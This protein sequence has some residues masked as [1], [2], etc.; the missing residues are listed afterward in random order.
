M[1]CFLMWTWR[2]FSDIWRIQVKRLGV[3]HLTNLVI[4]WELNFLVD[5]WVCILIFVVIFPWK[6]YLKLFIE[7]L[8][9]CFSFLNFIRRC[10]KLVEVFIFKII[11]SFYYHSHPL[12]WTTILANFYQ[13]KYFVDCT[14]NITLCPKETSL[15]FSF[16]MSLWIWPIYIFGHDSLIFLNFQ[17]YIQLTFSSHLYIYP[18]SS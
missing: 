16:N 18:Y 6:G 5:L 4:V 7:V 2:N 12:I 14:H 8:F 13:M 11:L 15:I 1:V 3:F 9:F 17:L 10:I